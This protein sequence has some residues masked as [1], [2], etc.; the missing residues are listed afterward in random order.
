ML[1]SLYRNQIAVG[2][3]YAIVLARAYLILGLSCDPHRA[4]LDV[5][6]LQS[7]LITLTVSKCAER[8]L[9]YEVTPI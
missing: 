6:Y 2:T 5:A 9:C 3:R 1:Y 7:V 4:V 8:T